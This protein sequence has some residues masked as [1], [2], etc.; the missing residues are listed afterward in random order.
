MVVFIV[1]EGQTSVVQVGGSCDLRRE[2]MRRPILIWVRLQD[3]GGPWHLVLV[4]VRDSWEGCVSVRW[5]SD[6]GLRAPHD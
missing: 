3:L 6:C 1:R 4:C 2:G 5:V